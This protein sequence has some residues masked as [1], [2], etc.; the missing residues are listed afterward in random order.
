MAVH[1]GIPGQDVTSWVYMSEPANSVQDQRAKNSKQLLLGLIFSLVV[2]HVVF[3]LID[4]EVWLVRVASGLGQIIVIALPIVVGWAVF[5]IV[6]P[7]SAANARKF[8]LFIAIGIF[9]Y[10]TLT[11]IFFGANWLLPLPGR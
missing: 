4:F 8:F 9:V 5:R 1:P 10:M 3:A 7:K 11:V 6:A 2:L